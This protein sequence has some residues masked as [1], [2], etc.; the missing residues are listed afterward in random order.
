VSTSRIRCAALIPG[1][2]VLAA[3]QSVAHAQDQP[4]TMVSL[5]DGALPPTRV[6]PGDEVV[7]TVF[8][9]AL[10]P[11]EGRWTIAERPAA[12][13]SVAAGG[14]YQITF[15]LP[16]EFPA[17]WDRLPVAYSDAQGTV[18]YDSRQDVHD[19]LG[20]ADI[21]D[22]TPL[23]ERSA[24]L[25]GA[26]PHASRAGRF[27][28]CGFF[29]DRRSRE[30]VTL[31]GA[32]M[33]APLTASTSELWFEVPEDLA[34]GLHEIDADP[35]VGFSEG[36]L[37]TIEIVTTGESGDSVE[38]PCASGNQFLSDWNESRTRLP[39]KMEVEP[40]ERSE[41]EPVIWLES[42]GG[43]T[44]EVF[45]AHVVGPAEE[46]LEFDGLFAVEP[47]SLSPEERDR[48]L[49]SVRRSAGSHLD[50]Q[51]NFYCLQFGA[52]APPEGVVY[53]IAPP[54]EQARFQPAARA[55][56]A[57]RTLYEA[58]FL[59]PDTTPES[60]FHSIRQWSIW[61]IEKGFDRQGFI[62]AF[63]EHARKNVEGAGQQWSDEFAERV[64]RSAEGRWQDV[65]MVLEQA[66][67]ATGEGYR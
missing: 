28:V 29:P 55:L 46:P 16:G 7:M 49:A 21:A 56:A 10:F 57:A 47:V 22:L 31:A 66:G 65:A 44:G 45:R 48:A 37:S 52:A 13:A 18:R 51:A 26:S 67:V 20:L 24:R 41:A 4:G 32:P 12:V 42:L 58:G 27:C 30:G 54:A 17:S 59:S 60:Y 43:S 6:I 34:P 14:D 25:T 62:E 8:D 39:A 1:I 11:A 35:A 38:C 50:V 15:H 40:E 23:V 2:A 33:G 3:T 9:P 19:A 36:A 63:L 64:Q 61:T 53:R 5:G